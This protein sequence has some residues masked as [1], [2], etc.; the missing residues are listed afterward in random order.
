MKNKTFVNSHDFY[1]KM[2]CLLISFLR[3]IT[4]YRQII[5]NLTGLNINFLQQIFN[6][7]NSKSL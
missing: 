1:S 7:I 5:P 6:I 4:L 3:K 2:F